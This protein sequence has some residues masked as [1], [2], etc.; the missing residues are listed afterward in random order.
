M[1]ELVTPPSAEPLALNDIKSVL[2]IDHDR[3]DDLLTEM[4]RTART[5][6]ERRLG[7]AFLTQTWQGRVDITPQASI[8]LR[9]FPLSSVTSVR[10]IAPD[11]M[12]SDASTESYQVTTGRQG[13]LT[14]VDTAAARLEVTFVSGVAAA[15]EIDAD[16]LRALYLLTAHYYEERELFR[17]DRYVPVPIAVDALTASYREMSL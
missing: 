4:H 7:F 13:R 16:I 5:Y 10:L 17:R 8:R 11:G 6:L 12:T 1:F 3:D 9:P 2:R 15:T 14:W